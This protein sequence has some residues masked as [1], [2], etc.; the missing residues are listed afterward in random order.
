[1]FRQQ[2]SFF[3][4]GNRYEIMNTTFHSATVAQTCY[5]KLEHQDFFLTFWG[6]EMQRSESICLYIQCRNID[7]PFPMPLHFNFALLKQDKFD[8]YEYQLHFLV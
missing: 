3:V 6:V 1:M 4:G 2:V 8:M 7:S 5:L